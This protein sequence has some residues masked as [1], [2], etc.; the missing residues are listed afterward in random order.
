MVPSMPTPRDTAAVA[1]FSGKVYVIGG[2]IE[3]ESRDTVEYFDPITNEWTIAVPLIQ[4]VRGAR[5]GVANGQIFVFGGSDSFELYDTIQR[6][7]LRTNS[8]SKVRES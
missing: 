1:N 3:D 8:W 5:A 4:K 6:Y 2:A 7:D